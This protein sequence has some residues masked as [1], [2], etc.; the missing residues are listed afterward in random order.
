MGYTPTVNAQNLKLY[1]GLC[2]TGRCRAS[3]TTLD[4]VAFGTIYFPSSLTFEPSDVGLPIA[5]SGGGPVNPL[6]PPPYSIQGALFVTTI[7]AYV[8]PSEVTLTD[9]PDTAYWNTG[10]ANIVLYRPCPFASDV[11]DLATNALQFQYNSSI[12]PGTADTLQFTTFNSLGGALGTDNPWVDQN[13]APALGMPVYLALEDT[14]DIFGGYIDSL[15]TSS[16]PGVD[17]VFCWSALCTS[18]MGLAN[19]RVVPPAIPQ[20]FDDIGAD[21]VFTTLVLDYLSNDGVSVTVPSGLPQITLAA[22]VGAN[23]GQLLD[24]VVTLLSTQATAYYW[25]S[26]PWRNYILATRTG[27]A[28]PWNITDGTDLFAGETPY[29]QSITA[30]HNQMANQVYGIA[31]ACLLNTINASYTGNGSATTFNLPEPAGGAPTIT[32]DSNPQTVGVVG[33]SGFDWY[34]SQGSS[35]ITQDSSGTVLTSADVLLVVYQPEVPAV[36][37]A[38][39]STSLQRLQAVEGTSAE[40]DYSFNVTQ[41][42]LPQPLLALVEAYASEYGEPATTCTLY[43]LWPGLAVGQLQSIALSA[44]NIPSGEYLIATLQMTTMGNIILW[45]YTAFGGANIGNAIT[46]LVQFIN[47]DQATGSII[48]PTTP[49]SATPSSANQHAVT[50]TPTVLALPNSVNQGDL[51]VVVLAGNADIG[52]PTITDTQSNTYTLAVFGQTGGGYPNQVGIWWTI[53]SAAGALTITSNQGWWIEASTYSGVDQASPVDVTGTATSGPPTVSITAPDD[54][55]VSALVNPN[56]AP[57]VIA[58]EVLLDYEPTALQPGIAVSYEA[59]VPVGSFTTSLQAEA[60]SSTQY[61]TAA[62]KI[63]PVAPPPQTTD[64]IGN[65]QG[66]VSNT[67]AL[68]LNEPVFGNGGVDI[69]TA[70]CDIATAAPLTGGGNLSPS[71]LSLAVSTATTAARGVVQPDGTTI[72]ISGAVIS[73]T[74]P[75][76]DIQIN[77]ATTLNTIQV[78]GTQVWQGQTEIQFNGTF[79]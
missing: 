9:A 40:Y 31:T 12:A 36:A 38:P 53:A 34:W 76:D 58:P 10:F 65:P 25:T 78:N 41:P 71:G 7:A 8:S 73:A 72:T 75:V 23:I 37:Q 16:L 62:F 20:T 74:A 44:A 57:S 48:T 17:G 54:I 42:I 43:T 56:T 28:A 60:S 30:T 50:G 47:R 22:P 33:Q 51:I 5:I 3:N 39:D 14:G 59:L 64:V 15:T 11:A 45:Q 35:T 77:G 70:T 32:L 21:V 61:V 49:I 55:V 69:K 29:S 18:W 79:I 52:G 46:A 68:V 24:Q 27:T 1:L 66:T 63:T 19:R 13:G 26:D 2:A 4:N 67:G 6:M